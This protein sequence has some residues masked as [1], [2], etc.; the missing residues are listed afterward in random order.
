MADYFDHYA[1]V[2][3]LDYSG[4]RRLWAAFDETI[5]PWV[6]DDRTAKLLDV[7]CGAGLVL[8][9]LHARGWQGAY[10]VDV[11]AGQVAFARSLGLPVEQTTDVPKWLADGPLLDFV[12][13]KDVLEHVPDAEVR[14]LLDA[15]AARLKPGARVCLIVPNANGAFAARMRYDDPTHYRAY[16][17][18]SLAWSLR[19]SGFRVENLSGDDCWR[20]QTLLGAA[21]FAVRASFR[22]MRRL[23]AMAEFGANGLR[24]P[25]ATNLIA[26]ARVAG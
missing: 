3:Q 25:L 10:G 9:W 14:P 7:G 15:I 4:R 16:T 19:Q 6:P 5:G 23:E 17:E 26:V 21:Q 2:N 18:H 20:P 11:D 22:A 24:I 8:E 12:L 1:Q 13:L